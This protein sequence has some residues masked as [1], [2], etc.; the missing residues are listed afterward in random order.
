MDRRDEQPR[1][2]KVEIIKCKYTV[3]TV[4]TRLL[5]ALFLPGIWPVFCLRLIR[6]TYPEGQSFRMSYS[7]DGTEDDIL[8]TDVRDDTHDT[9]ED[10]TYD[11]LPYL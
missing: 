8:W 3:C 1:Q 7:L 6:A 11:D 5:A 4:Y 10:D 9:D 2:V